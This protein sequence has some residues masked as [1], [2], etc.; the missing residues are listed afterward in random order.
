MGKRTYEIIY[1]DPPWQYGGSGGTKWL[2]ADNY[3][4]TIDDNTLGE[5]L[6]TKIKPLINK[7]NCLIFCWVTAPHLQKSIDLICK[8]LDCKY[9]TVGF[10]WHKKRANVGNYTMSSC[11]YCLIFKAGKIPKD[12]VRNPG[13]L[14]FLSEA[15]SRHS[16]KPGEIRKRIDKMFPLS[17]KLEIFARERVENWD[18]I[19]LDLGD[20]L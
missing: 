10:V 19:G 12:R 17:N 2:R 15:I 9:I 20:S 6:S 13:V 3:Y 8:S 18:A 5:K 7:Q 14:Q 1:M 16:A 4:P 11:E